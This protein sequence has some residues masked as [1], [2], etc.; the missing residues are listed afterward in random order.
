MQIAKIPM[1]SFIADMYIMMN[2]R[3]N[4]NG[5]TRQEVKNVTVID[6]GIVL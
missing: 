5:W 2:R 4:T 3:K 6:L 1:D